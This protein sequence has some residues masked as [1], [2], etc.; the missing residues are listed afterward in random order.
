MRAVEQQTKNRHRALYKHHT[1]YT[2]IDNLPKH[3]QHAQPNLLFILPS[4]PPPPSNPQCAILATQH[5]GGSPISTF[6]PIHSNLCSTLRYQ[7]CPPPSLHPNHTHPISHDHL[8]TSQQMLRPIRQPLNRRI[9]TRDLPRRSQR[10]RERVII[11]IFLFPV[12]T[13]P[14][15]R[16][17][18]QRRK[19]LANTRRRAR[20]MKILKSRKEKK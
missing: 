8:A 3:P 5:T 4:P 11:R 2:E 18:N 12:T 9:P 15:S 1:G 13:Q 7:Q 20:H 14:V 16:L 6:H 10:K 17:S 19:W